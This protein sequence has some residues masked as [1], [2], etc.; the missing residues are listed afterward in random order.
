MLT[1]KNIKVAIISLLV[2]FIAF[3]I[4]GCAQKS[5]PGYQN[6]G[7]KELQ[8]ILQ[9]EKD[10]LLVDVREPDELAD[11]GFI[12]GAVNIPV[13]QVE[14]NLN[15][16]PKT[17]KLIIYCRT[18]RRSASVADF[19]AGKGYTNVYNLEGGIVGWPYEKHRPNLNKIISPGNN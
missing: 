16:L 5:T 8:T 6:I 2:L 10:L 1:T 13:G 11:T 18:G 17:G 9:K 14:K 19:L 3:I 12:P 15:S 7:S 4:G